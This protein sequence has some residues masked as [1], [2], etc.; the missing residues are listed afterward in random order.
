MS[1][2]Y[3]IGKDINRGDEAR[4]K[5]GL[6][7]GND[8]KIST[9]EYHHEEIMD[10][11]IKAIEFTKL[12]RKMRSILLLRLIHGFTIER[13]Q[14]HLFFHGHL[15]GNSRDELIALEAEG[16][17]LVMETLKNNSMQDIVASINAKPSVL[18]GLRNE[19]TT[20]KDNL[21]LS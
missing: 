3:I 17:R 2:D 14:I 15:I 18:T 7:L 6:V 16:K 5:K 1:E 11:F 12:D 9:A 19:L 4:L 10:Q 13:M 20:P 8:G 21:G